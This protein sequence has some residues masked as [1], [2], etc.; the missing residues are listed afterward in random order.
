VKPLEIR[1][2]PDEAE[3]EAILV[4]LADE[5]AGKPAGSAW[6]EAI[7]PRHDDARP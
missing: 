3:R 6:A 5:D 1:P 7:L 2:E 4:A